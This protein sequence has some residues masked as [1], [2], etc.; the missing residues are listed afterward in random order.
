MALHNIRIQVCAFAPR[1]TVP[2][3]GEIICGVACW[4][5][6][7]FQ[8][9]TPDPQRPKPG[10]RLAQLG[11]WQIRGPDGLTKNPS[12]PPRSTAAIIPAFP[13]R[14][15]PC[16]PRFASLLS[17]GQVNLHPSA[18]RGRL[19]QA[20]PTGARIQALANRNLADRARHRPVL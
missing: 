14:Q 11:I 1:Q 4:R 18:F 12:F 5:S 17:S 6:A 8:R 16:S 7:G 19:E 15:R 20:A 10:G 2:P 3:Q 9:S 13:K